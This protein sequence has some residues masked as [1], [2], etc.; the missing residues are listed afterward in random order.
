MP[1]DVF[2]FPLTLGDE[3]PAPEAPLPVFVKD[4]VEDRATLSMSGVGVELI[5]LTQDGIKC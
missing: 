1:Q 3:F 4:P 5:L 2:H